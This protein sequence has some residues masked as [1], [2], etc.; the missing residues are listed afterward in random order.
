MTRDTNR[1][2]R[3]RRSTTP[4]SPHFI[5]VRQARGCKREN[6]TE[7][8]HHVKK[9]RK[10]RRRSMGVG[11]TRF[12]RRLFSACIFS[13]DRLNRLGRSQSYATRQLSLANRSSGP[14][15]GSSQ[16]CG[17][18]N[19][20]EKRSIHTTTDESTDNH[21]H[22]DAPTECPACDSSEITLTGTLWSCGLCGASGVCRGEL[23]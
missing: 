5:G 15:N 7:A 4:Q 11:S 21:A 12:R 19:Q 6:H 18:M 10:L 8:T 3:V 23:A 20:Q 16:Q 14:V 13:P 2:T 1:L 9:C 22:T 17:S